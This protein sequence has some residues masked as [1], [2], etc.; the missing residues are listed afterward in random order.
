MTTPE[1]PRPEDIDP[2]N[3]APLSPEQELAVMPYL[4][5]QLVPLL[6]AYKRGMIVARSEE[7]EA[8]LTEIDATSGPESGRAIDPDEPFRPR[9]QS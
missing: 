6:K 1:K 2:A 7:E 3:L 9:L 8:I 4:L 5:E